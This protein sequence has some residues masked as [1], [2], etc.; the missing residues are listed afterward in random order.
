VTNSRASIRNL[1]DWRT[2]TIILGF[3]ICAAVSI[4]LWLLSNRRRVG[5]PFAVMRDAISRASARLP[6]RWAK[7]MRLIDSVHPIELLCQLSLFLMHPCDSFPDVEKHA[8][9][10]V[11]IELVT[12]YLLH[13]PPRGEST[14]TFVGANILNPLERELADYF[15]DYSISILEPADPAREPIGTLITRMKGEALHVR[16][17]GIPSQ[18]EQ[19]ALGMYAPNGHW[20]LKYLGFTIE[21][22]FEIADAI[23]VLVA[24]KL[25]DR[26]EWAQG[27]R[28]EALLF[29]GQILNADE[30]ELN[31]EE[32]NLRQRL[33]AAGVQSAADMYGCSCMFFNF[34][35]ALGFTSEELIQAMAGRCDAAAATAFLDRMSQKLGEANDPPDPLGFN[36]LAARPLINDSG[37]Y[38]LPVPPMLHEA[39]LS[40]FHYDLMADVAYRASY[41]KARARWLEQTALATFKKLL[42]GA[43]VHWNLTYG[44]KKAG[45]ELDGLIIYDN[46]LLFVECKWKTLT[47]D[48]RRGNYEA[49]KTDLNKSI[50]AAFSQAT[51]ARDYV[52][53]SSGSADFVD[54]SGQTV[55]IDPK[56]VSE[57]Y[58]V[59]LTGRGAFAVLAANLPVLVP[60]DM[61]PNDQYPWAVSLIDLMLVAEL[62]DVPCEL[63]DYLRKRDTFVRTR[64]SYVHDEWD[65]LGLYL[66]GHLDLEQ[67]IFQDAQY[68]FFDGM[69]DEIDRYLRARGNPDLPVAAKPARVIPP[70]LLQY[71]AAIETS[72]AKG[73]SDFL[74]ALLALPDS[75]LHE[76]W[77]AVELT[78]SKTAADK[79]LH[80]VALQFK[81][82]GF[83][84]LSRAGGADE[85]ARYMVAYSMAKKYDAKITT[86]LGMC[87]DVTRSERP[88]AI[89]YLHGKWKQ[90]PELETLASAVLK[91]T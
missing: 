51:R 67:P 29:Y 17:E 78:L 20:F 71:M 34:R 45:K 4:G 60:E 64:R 6:K 36:P 76:L 1:R 18:L 85:L 22:A 54:D 7:I 73:R 79:K 25:Q 74:I 59:A 87:V 13:R 49:L 8:R 26:K 65:L 43:D 24:D 27:K 39:L 32:K 37:Q 83:A 19:L 88:G 2:K 75:A 38:Y 5:D 21:N 23:S 41:D 42:P 82:M 50:V 48:A 58:E 72:G 70:G 86:W 30:S 15:R 52:K 62:L 33:E 55:S 44:D 56:E 31:K 35:E 47:L 80:S 53:S 40:T 16:G 46:K 90:D 61:L 14:E 84:F 66:S 57:T 3:A 68:I 28:D 81:D 10:Q 9:W 63:F 91:R 69:D 11:R 77:E 12:W 89:V